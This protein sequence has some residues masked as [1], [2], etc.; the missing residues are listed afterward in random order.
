MQF[1]SDL[2]HLAGAQAEIVSRQQILWHIRKELGKF[3]LQLSNLLPNLDCRLKA[4]GGTKFTIHGKRHNTY[5]KPART[6][7]NL[8]WKESATS[9]RSDRFLSN[10]SFHHIIFG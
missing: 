1:L 5:L 9:S 2:F 10:E 8:L 7:R 6:V 3:P 4:A